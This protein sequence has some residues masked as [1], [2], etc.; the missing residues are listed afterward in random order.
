MIQAPKQTLTNCCLPTPPKSDMPGALGEACFTTI[1]AKQAAITVK[2]I[3]V[4]HVESD[5]LLE[6]VVANLSR[7]E[8]TAVLCSPP[9]LENRHAGEE[10]R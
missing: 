7:T 2:M 10:A 8:D 6:K 9:T 3:F 5:E 4:Y 1:A